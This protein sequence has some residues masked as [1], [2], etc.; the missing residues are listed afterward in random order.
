M[1]EFEFILAA[2]AIVAGTGLVG[3][4]FSRITKLIRLWM[5][6]KYNQNTVGSVPKEFSSFK[7]DVERRLATIEAIIAEEQSSP[8]LS[9][10]SEN[11]GDTEDEMRQLSNL[12][13]NRI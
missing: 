11:L 1:S 5:E 9:R 7:Q 12:L 6:S 10:T 3:F 4:I 2:T 13:K 8:I